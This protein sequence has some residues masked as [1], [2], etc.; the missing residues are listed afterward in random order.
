MWVRKR[1][2]S[3]TLRVYL[4]SA[5]GPQR[6]IVHAVRGLKTFPLRNAQVCYFTGGSEKCRGRDSEAGSDSGVGRGRI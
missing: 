5:R 6:D 4:M 1:T 3:L 2:Y